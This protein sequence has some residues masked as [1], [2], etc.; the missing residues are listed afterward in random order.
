MTLGKESMRAIVW[1]RQDLRL[2][3]NAALSK[4][5][6]ECDEVIPIF[7]HDT[8]PQS[9][10]RLGA[11]SNAWLHESLKSLAADLKKRG[12]TLVLRKGDAFEVLEDLV[13][14]TKATH[15]FWNRCY[16]PAIRERDEKIKSHFKNAME[17]RSFKGNLVFEPWEV[18]KKDDTPY[19]VFTP[20]WKKSL[21]E[22]RRPDPISVPSDLK[23]MTNPPESLSLEGLKLLPTKEP[24]WHSPMMSFW[25]VGE[26]A[27]MKTLK[28]F[29]EDCVIAYKAER[30]FPAISAT[31][32][33][34]PYLHFGEIS[35]GQI[36][37]FARKFAGTDP[38]RL[39]A[40]TPFLRQIAWREFAYY[41]LFH[42]PHTLD[43][44]LNKKF[45]RFLW[46]QDYQDDLQKWK[47]GITG[48]PIVDAG[49]REL[50]ATGTMHNRVR[51][52]VASFLT[53]N[54]LIPWQEGET[55]FRDT[56]VD[57]DLANNAMGW[58]WVAGTGVDASPYFRIFNPRLQSKKFDK[59]GSYI[60]RWVPELRDVDKKHIHDPSADL[61]EACNYPLPIVDLKMTRDRALARYKEMKS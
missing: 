55:W 37:F 47:L 60:R 44:P 31:S 6:D 32:T 19:R 1:L 50:W 5:C 14:T 30:D 12:T 23:G 18:L 2:A 17:V 59:E 34:S 49:M 13:Q 3:D 39:E 15:L 9:I 8:N 33:L 58:Q 53:K 25:R 24:D 42:F 21:L 28:E 41:L 16:E 56:L 43:Q 7:I 27:A 54:L 38:E 10:S 46:S 22:E 45:E 51:M 36:D 52:L 20:Y 35:P 26:S 29:L 61:A 4:A 57:A 11:A 40:I 48:Y